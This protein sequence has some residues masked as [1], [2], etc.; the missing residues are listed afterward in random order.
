METGPKKEKPGND[1]QSG[2]TLG[3]GASR[4]A[5]NIS[6]GSFSDRLCVAI[7]IKLHTEREKKQ[8]CMQE[9]HFWVVAATVNDSSVFARQLWSGSRWI[10]E[11]DRPCNPESTETTA[12]A[13]L[14]VA[15]L[16]DEPRKCV[17]ARTC[18]SW[19][20]MTVHASEGGSGREGKGRNRER[21]RRI[22]TA[23]TRTLVIFFALKRCIGAERKL[24]ILWLRPSLSKMTINF[25]NVNFESD[26]FKYLALGFP[27][28]PHAEVSAPLLVLTT[29]KAVYL[30]SWAS[31]H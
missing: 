11:R 6:R 7:K 4:C 1:K 9:P 31:V 18:E 23:A 5:R 29:S 3:A 30:F 13:R 16:K 19:E 20:L 24:L 21:H 26:T 12:E 2:E 28:S 25:L 10:I 14:P 8:T 27:E 22:E 15:S 17:F